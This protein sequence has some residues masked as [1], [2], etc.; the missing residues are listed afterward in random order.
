L[1]PL[2]GFLALVAAG[3]VGLLGVRA[4]AFLTSGGRLPGPAPAV[5]PE[6]RAAINAECERCHEAQAAQWRGSRHHAAFTNA[7]FQ[8]AY[9][10][11]PTTFCRDCHAPE[12]ARR[13]SAEGDE[14]GIGCVTCH[15][16]GEAVLAAPSRDGEGLRI[17]PHRLER[18]ADFGSSGACA[19]CHEFGFGDDARREEPAW[20]QRTVSEHAES[21]SSESCAGCHMPRGSHDFGSTRRPEAHRAALEATAD[22]TSPTAITLT[23]TPRGVGHAYPTGDLFRRVAL[24]AEVVGDDGEERAS[25]VVYLARR[26]EDEPARLGPPLRV[27]RADDRVPSGASKRVE[28]DLGPPAID[29]VIHWTVTYERVLS[30]RDGA[31]DSALIDDAIL[32]HAGASEAPHER[33]R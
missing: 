19:G 26:F 12:S 7:A 10:V 5:E 24:R 11:E 1:R 4:Y 13:E 29:R 15:L 17:A 23:L 20:M 2:K 8:R 33:V 25:K 3:G 9:Q 30:V 14:L 22:R 18:S 31:F 32:L 16:A 21:G 6:R 27:E 28:L